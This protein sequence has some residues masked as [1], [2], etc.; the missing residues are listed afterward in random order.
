MKPRPYGN[1]L[2]GGF[3]SQLFCE[4]YLGA[5]MPPLGMILTQVLEER[6]ETT[7]HLQRW[8]P[9]KPCYKWGEKN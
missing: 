7:N 5:Y 8:A 1:K 2:V 9:R 3:L 4:K 6:F